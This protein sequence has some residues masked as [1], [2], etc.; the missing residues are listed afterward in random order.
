MLREVKGMFFVE[1]AIRFN[2][3]PRPIQEAILDLY[4]ARSSERVFRTGNFIV[5][6]ELTT[7]IYLGQ[8]A[9]FQ[10][11]LTRKRF[12]PTKSVPKGAETCI[13]MLTYLGTLIL[14][15]KPKWPGGPLKWLG[16]SIPLRMVSMARLYNPD[17]KRHDGSKGYLVEELELGK[18]AH[19]WTTE[20]GG[21]D[22]SILRGLAVNPDAVDG[23]EL[24]E[25]AALT[26]TVSMLVTGIG[27]KTE[28]MLLQPRNQ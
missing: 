21:I 1:G 13:A 9:A 20:E 17:L 6:I 25:K 27:E 16:D 15:G 3:Q 8:L 2:A 10:D 24:Q 12:D 28:Q 7:E 26:S 22:S 18:R 23:T 19:I 14:L 5:N 11:L 4:K